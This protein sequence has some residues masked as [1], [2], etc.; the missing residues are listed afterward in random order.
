MSSSLSPLVARPSLRPPLGKKE[1]FD[2]KPVL[3]RPPDHPELAHCPRTRTFRSKQA[4]DSHVAAY[5]DEY[6]E[7]IKEKEKK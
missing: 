4:W 5:E 1:Y 7:N 6:S 2:G 3:H